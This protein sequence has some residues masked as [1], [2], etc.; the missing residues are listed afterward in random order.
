MHTA[1]VLLLLPAAFAPAPAIGLQKQAALIQTII[2]TRS[3]AESLVKNIMF[4]VEYEEVIAP[5]VINE[6]QLL[7]VHRN[8]MVEY[9][10]EPKA[11]IRLE[12]Q[13]L[14]VE[15]LAEPLGIRSVFTDNLKEER[16]LDEGSRTRFL[17]IKKRS[18]L[19]H[20]LRK[21]TF[22]IQSGAE[23]LAQLIQA[24]LDE[25]LP[26]GLDERQLSDSTQ[27]VLT[28][29][30]RVNDR[31]YEHVYWLDP[32]KLYYPFKIETYRDGKLVRRRSSKPQYV[33][34]DIWMPLEAVYES[35]GSQGQRL[36]KVSMKVNE[37]K[38]N[39]PEFPNALFDIEITPGTKVTDSRGSETLEYVVGADIEAD[40]VLEELA[41]LAAR[42]Q[43]VSPGKTGSGTIRIVRPSRAGRPGEAAE[44]KAQAAVSIDR[45][46]CDGESILLQQPSGVGGSSAMARHLIY[47]AVAA[48]ALLVITTLLAGRLKRN[49]RAAKTRRAG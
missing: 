15:G 28:V 49:A 7:P 23:P 1:G 5:G 32:Q 34:E 45:K 22:F 41:S 19:T 33:Q 40:M 25:G 42:G 35:F 13:T 27:V 17:S 36:E 9:I 46:P 2:E 21:P 12:E 3:Y 18:G 24:A 4:H 29:P 39:M 8:K 31:A 30:A 11:R 14:K 44:P 43:Y 38:A 47:L 16:L 37:V 20:S 10:Y 6:Q 48:S 26:V